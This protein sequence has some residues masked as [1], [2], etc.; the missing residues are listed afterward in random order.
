MGVFLLLL[1]IGT[2]GVFHLTYHIIYKHLVV[3]AILGAI[4]SVIAVIFLMFTKTITTKGK[5]PE[6]INF[7]LLLGLFIVPILLVM[8]I[9]DAFTQ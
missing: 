8:A 3:G 5:I 2:T 4:G 9:F 7:K 6:N 1:G